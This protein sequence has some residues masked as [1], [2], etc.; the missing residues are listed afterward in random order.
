MASSQARA[1]HA[2][3]A[4]LPSG[5][6]KR[7]A[8]ARSCCATEGCT[9]LALGME[10]NVAAGQQAMCRTSSSAAMCVLPYHEPY[11]RLQL[12][13]T[14]VQRAPIALLSIKPQR[15]LFMKLTYQDHTPE[16]YEPPYF[17]P[18]DESGVGHFK[19]S[20]TALGAPLRA[21]GSALMCT[22]LRSPRCP[23]GPVGYLR[24]E[25]GAAP[26]SVSVCPHV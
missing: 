25:A 2:G 23:K 21:G 6:G 22:L 11:W 18:V 26:H 8:R 13:T 4:C 3:G 1:S 20:C 17:V 14:G 24:C 9:A 7:V 16:E 5:F 12:A 10:G 15:Y 19:V